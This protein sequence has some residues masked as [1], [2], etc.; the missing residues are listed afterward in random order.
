MVVLLH[1]VTL[2]TLHNPGCAIVADFGRY[3]DCAADTLFPVGYPEARRPPSGLTRRPIMKPDSKNSRQ[4][5]EKLLWFPT[6]ISTK[7]VYH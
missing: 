6:I 1:T 7:C 2:I 5:E 4:S 3:E